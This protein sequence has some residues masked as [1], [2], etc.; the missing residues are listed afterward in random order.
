MFLATTALSLYNFRTIKISSLYFDKNMNKI[1]MY[2]I[3]N[4]DT[5]RKATKWLNQNNIHHQ[6]HDLRTD[7][8]TKVMLEKWVFAVGYEVIL[9][10]RG[11]TWRK[12]PME[13]QKKVS[14]LNI[15]QLLLEQPAMIKR[16]ILDVDGAIHVGFIL[17]QYKAIFAHQS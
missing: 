13:T 6:F 1:T 12:L 14:R 3:K 7:T 10:K 15:I 8:L 4:C 11:T 2:G 5:I 17:D 9:N 16:P